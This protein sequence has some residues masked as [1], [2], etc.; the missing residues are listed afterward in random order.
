MI[1]KESCDTEDWG[2][3]LIFSC[4]MKMYWYI[5]NYLDFSIQIVYVATLQTE[6][7]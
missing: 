7:T 5:L 3:F 6:Y 1:S 4:I 2:L